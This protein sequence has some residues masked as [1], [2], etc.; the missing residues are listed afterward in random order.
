MAAGRWFGGWAT[1]GGGDERAHAAHLPSMAMI[2]FGVIAGVGQCRIEE[3]AVQCLIQERDKAI[4][5]YP[6][7]TAGDG[8]DDEVRGAVGGGLQFG[9]GP[10]K[11][12]FF[13]ILR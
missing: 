8:R 11:H 4:A 9:E 2:G 5:I 1:Q 3:D 13:A 7:S 6:W 12:G 10:I